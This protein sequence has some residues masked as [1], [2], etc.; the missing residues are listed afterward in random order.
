VDG[1]GRTARVTSFVVLCA[2]LGYRLPG[3]TTIPEQISGNKYYPYYKALEFA[4]AA[5]QKD[6]QIDVA[7]MEAL[8]SELLAKQ[9]LSVIDDAKKNQTKP[10]E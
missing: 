5:Y 8:L 4:D 1:N 6:K 3:S 10:S 7:D 2:R 9:L